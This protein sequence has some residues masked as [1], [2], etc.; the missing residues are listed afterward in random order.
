MSSSPTV[1]GVRFTPARRL[2]RRVGLLGRVSL[3]LGLL[4]LDDVPLLQSATGEPRL[5]FPEH[6]LRA[7]GGVSVRVLDDAGWKAVS[8]QVVAEL[9]HR[10][11]L[12]ARP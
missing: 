4:A 9:E 7:A 11:A 8:A 2:D 10:G 3:D 1:T 5:G 6:G 12:E